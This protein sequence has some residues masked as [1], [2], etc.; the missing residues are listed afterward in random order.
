MKTY[1][2][3]Y[4]NQIWESNMGIN[5]NIGKQIWESNMGIKYEN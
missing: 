1:E 3:K 4:G 5:E 2:N